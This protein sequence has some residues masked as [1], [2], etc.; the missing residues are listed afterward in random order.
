[1]NVCKFFCF[2]RKAHDRQM[3]WP[4]KSHCNGHF[5]WN[6]MNNRS[7]Q[8]YSR[9]E[10]GFM[11]TAVQHGWKEKALFKLCHVPRGTQIWH[12]FLLFRLANEKISLWTLGFLRS[13]TMWISRLRYA[14]IVM[15]ELRYR[16]TNEV[17]LVQKSM[18]KWRRQA[19]SRPRPQGW[20]AGHFK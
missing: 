11:S 9:I 13:S 19:V 7:I 6:L 3:D 17:V 12:T 16:L 14:K 4:D 1:M 18:A 8:K 2:K 5:S 20:D 15:R 10:Q